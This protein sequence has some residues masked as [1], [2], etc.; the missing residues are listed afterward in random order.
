MTEFE[1]ALKV[2][3]QNEE[4]HPAWTKKL[5]M[6]KSAIEECK[7]PIPKENPMRKDPSSIKM[8]KWT[9]IRPWTP[10]PIKVLT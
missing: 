2:N 5:N 8:Q 4:P 7:D 10:S 3:L 1:C 9:S 6:T